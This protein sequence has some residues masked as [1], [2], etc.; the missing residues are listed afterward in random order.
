MDRDPAGVLEIVKDLRSNG[1]C[2]GKDFDFAYKP[3]IW[4]NFNGD[5]VYNRST[6]FT[7]YTDELAS[8]FALKYDHEISK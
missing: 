2:Q 7:F 3:P 6:V 4:D 1:L 5:V 8:W